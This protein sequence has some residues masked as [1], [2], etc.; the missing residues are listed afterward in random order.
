[1]GGTA[2]GISP[3]CPTTLVSEC[4][5]IP[6]YRYVTY[7][8]SAAT[9]CGTSSINGTVAGVCDQPTLQVTSWIINGQNVIADPTNDGWDACGVPF[10]SDMAAFMNTFDPFAGNWT[11]VSSVACAY[12]IRSRAMPATGTDYGTITATNTD[13]G[14]TITFDPVQT[15]VPDQVFRRTVEMDC[16]G[17]VTE[18]WT[19]DTGATVPA[20]PQNQLVPCDAQTTP[21]AQV[22]PTNRVRPRIKRYTGAVAFGNFDNGNDVQ[23]VTLTVLAGEVQVQAAGSGA[24]GAAEPTTFADTAVVPSGVSLT[25]GV[26]GDTRDVA[27]DGSLLFTGTSAAS[28]FILT[29]TEHLHL[30]VQ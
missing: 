21:G 29:W 3:D 28:D 4:W 2:G 13:T 19:D 11:V 1:M 17:T 26:D 14:G 15:V 30:D 5:K 20:P 8:N 10:L 23:S 7:D 6:G 24:V 22:V 18:S 25:W 27:L 9:P 12:H 16:D